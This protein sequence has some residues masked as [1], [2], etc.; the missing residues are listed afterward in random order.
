MRKP[1]HTHFPLHSP[2]PQV[3]II[4][5]I[6]HSR[7]FLALLKQLYQLLPL[8]IIYLYPTRHTPFWHAL[9]QMQI[10][11]IWLPQPPQTTSIQTLHT[12]QQILHLLKQWKPLIVNT[13]LPWADR[14]GLLAAYHANTPIRVWTRHDATTHYTVFP[15]GRFYH[16]LFKHLATDVISFSTGMHRLLTEAEGWQ[17]DRV[18]ILHHPIP[19]H[20]YQQVHPARILQV[21][22]RYGIPT[23]PGTF[24]VGMIARMIA[25]KDHQTFLDALET[26]RHEMPNL[27]VIL[28]NAVGPEL[29]RVRRRLTQLAIPHALIPFE[30]DSPALYHT[31]H[32]IV[33][34]PDSPLAESFGQTYIEAL[35]VGLPMIITLSGIARDLFLHH[36]PPGIHIVRFRT[37]REVA[38]TLYHLYQQWQRQPDQIGPARYLQAYAPYLQA[39]Q[40]ERI[41]RQW[42]EAFEKMME[43]L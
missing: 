30:E 7:N 35:A 10:P 28:A 9:R 36:P 4:S 40:P 18:W 12:Y 8:R 38:R 33:H 14:L 5:E 43:R 20:E 11:V 27:F 29:P 25:W 2:A 26:I 31:F 41:A 15:T 17:P 39:F 13:H 19:I 24:R 42:Q 21:H 16:H 1:A 22:R 3:L 6:F 37:P 32:T 23:D 34:I